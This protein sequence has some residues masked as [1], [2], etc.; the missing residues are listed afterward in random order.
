[1]MQ[2]LQV[3]TR[4]LAADMYYK[5]APVLR[6]SINYPWLKSKLYGQAAITLNRY[7]ADRAEAYEQYLRHS[8]FKTAVEEYDH[9]IKNGYPVRVFE[10]LENF[11]ITFNQD[12]TL[13]LYSER[14]EYTGGAHGNTV[15]SSDTWDLQTSRRV[16]LDEIVP[17]GRNYIIDIIINDIQA[18]M[19][20]NDGWYFDDYADNV[21]QYF[22]P[23]SFYLTPDGVVIYFQQYEIAP[24]ASGIPEFTLP[25]SYAVLRPRCE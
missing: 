15:R 6:Y 22:N 2:G 8:L 20:S 3:M 24:Y 23:D 1:M 19:S 11:N 9:S 17:C 16:T 10:A 5:N 4:T 7:Y 18:Q 25:Y 13:S 12:C 21:E 14:Y